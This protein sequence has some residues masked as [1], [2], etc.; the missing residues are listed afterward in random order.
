VTSTVL[1]IVRNVIEQTL[2]T[3]H[4]R[5]ARPVAFIENKRPNFEE[6]AGILRLSDQSGWWTNFGPVSSLLEKALEQHLNLPS[7]RAVVMCSSGTAA[8][9][10][11]TG[12]KEYHA[13]RRLRWVISAFS[14]RASCLGPLAT[15]TV[16]DCNGV[17]TLDVEALASLDRDSW[18]GVVVTNVFGL[19]SDLRNYIE[20]CRDERKELI[21]DNA[22]LLNGFSR[23]DPHWCADEILSFH[24]TKPW[25]MGEG[26]CAVLSRED[27]QVF[28]SLINGGHGLCPQAH[29]WA[30]NSKISDFSSALILQRL[31]GYQ[32]WSYAYQEQARRILSIAMDVGLRPLAA[33][34]LSTLTPPHLPMVAQTTLA[35]ADL[36]NKSFVMEKY[37]RPLSA[38]CPT[39][40]AIYASIVNIPCHPGMALLADEEIRYALA[41]TLQGRA[42]R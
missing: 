23:A 7:S 12:L 15:A 39:A 24:Q 26:G 34:D 35:G 21:I 3:V 36:V 14:F 29:R 20:F 30:T 6:L 18:D 10:A 37:Y 11:L 22:C 28:R 16:L 9:L 42:G 32:E 40:A 13:G 19:R 33:M 17:G 25:G 8:L 38:A 2:A 27:A 1:S 5:P 31:L 4:P 41:L